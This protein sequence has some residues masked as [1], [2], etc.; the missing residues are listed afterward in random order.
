M[1]KTNELNVKMTITR[2]NKILYTWKKLKTINKKKNE[3]R[4]KEKEDK[5]SI[6]LKNKNYEELA[7]ESR[8]SKDSRFRPFCG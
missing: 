4:R 5:K 7:Y 8:F 3:I 2:H 1:E 6:I